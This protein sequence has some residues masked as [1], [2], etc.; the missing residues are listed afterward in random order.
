MSEKIIAEYSLRTSEF[1]AEIN[2]IIGQY[3]KVDV[4]SGKVNTEMQQ[5]LNKTARAADNV[6]KEINQI[7][8]STQAAGAKINTFTKGVTGQFA[9]IGA[10]AGALGAAIGVAFGVEQII[11]FGKAAITAASDLGEVESKVN[12]IFGSGSSAV[13]SFADNAANSFGQSKKS[14]LDGAATFGIFGK[15]AGLTGNE[16]AKFS[17][18]FVGLSSDLASFN[19]TTPEEAILAIGAALRGEAEPIRRYGVLLDDATLRQQALEL[20]IIKTTKEAL[21]PQ[22]KV[23]A[24]QAAIY[25]Q[26]AVAQGDFARTSG[27]LANQQR[28]LTANF[29]NFQAQ[30]GQGLLPI[31]NDLVAGLNS[32][33]QGEIEDGI[34]KLVSFADAIDILG[35]NPI[36]NL[37]QGV[38]GLV[39]GFKLLFA[40]SF[41]EGFKKLLSGVIDLNAAINPLVGITR[42][43]AEQFIEVDTELSAG[44]QNMQRFAAATRLFNEA[45]TEGGEKLDTFFENAQKLAKANGIEL[46]K[47]KFDEL[48]AAQRKKLDID[49]EDGKSN[50]K[51]ISYYERLNKELKALNE[52]I[53]NTIALGGIVSQ[54][55][56]ARVQELEKKLRETKIIFEA[57]TNGIGEGTIVPEAD[58]GLFETELN[59]FLEGEE[60]KRQASDETLEWLRENLKL[61]T[62]ATLLA[63]D[64]EIAARRLQ[65]QIEA[66]LNARKLE[67]GF[68]VAEGT[69]SAFR[70]VFN[71]LG[72]D[73]AEFAAFQKVL[74]IFDVSLKAAQAIAGATAAASAGDPYTVAIRIAAAVAAVGAAIGTAISTINGTQQPNAPQFASGT[75][76]V[77]LGK[78]RKGIDTV[79]AWLNEGEA[80]IPTQENKKYP[81]LAKAW[82]NG[83]LDSY[84]ANSF[85]AP[86]LIKMEEKRAE[87]MRADFASSLGIGSSGTGFDDLRLYM[88]TRKGNE[89]LEGIYLNT[90]HKTKKR[91]IQ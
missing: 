70:D 85:V 32:L 45:V 84:I 88:A 80:V 44:E 40:G 24:A 4:V 14:A 46:T 9:Q 15:A 87:K 10:S 90:K 5:D 38:M 56:V 78:N 1:K 35:V 81:G 17:T 55:D 33:F 43:L 2:G 89:I 82:I 30:I 77:P 16:L 13:K 28:I 62:E 29:E 51:A 25:K 34:R 76:F 7:P 36:T 11:Q 79:A 54:S 58:L 63:T 69:L 42:T 68:A 66:D 64:E 8:R 53:I 50:E 41:E 91:Q 61:Q 18:D 12:Q 21:T 83:N 67:A 20:G 22:Q 52:K 48:V 39:D 74:A 6:G 27:Q 65:A 26:T 71:A 3:N 75:D 57:I 49:V 60:I 31:V 72:K 86:K 37:V 23:L 73:N 59:A 47:E 19:N